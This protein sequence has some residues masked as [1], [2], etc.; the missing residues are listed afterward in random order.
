MKKTNRKNQLL[1]V[2]I[3]LFLMSF[4]VSVSADPDWSKKA[5]IHIDNTG[6]GALSYYHVHLNITYDSDMKTDFSDIRVKN[7]V[8][9][10]FVPY[11]VEDK[12]NSS[13]CNLWFNATSI[14]ASSWSNTTYYLYY[15]DAA[16]SSA[17]NG[18]TTFLFFDDFEDGTTI[19]E[20]QLAQSTSFSED[21]TYIQGVASDGTYLYHAHTGTWGGKAGKLDKDSK[22]G[23]NIATHEGLY[24]AD[25]PLT[26][27][28]S[29]LAYHDGYLYLVGFG[30]PNGGTGVTGQSVAKYDPSDLS[31]VE[32]YDISPFD[33]SNAEGIAFYNNHWWLTSHE[34]SVIVKYNTSWGHVKTY[35]IDGHGDTEGEY[36]NG[37]GYQ[38]ITFWEE[39]DG[40]IFAGLSVHQTCDHG[41]ALYI[42]QYNTSGDSFS[43]QSFHTSG[44]IV[45][46][47]GW[48]C[49]SPLDPSDTWWAVRHSS[50]V[51]QSLSLSDLVNPS[52]L[53][54]F[55]SNYASTDY[56]HSGSYC[57]K[58][59]VSG[60]PTGRSQSMDSLTLSNYSYTWW[61][62]LTATS[63]RCLTTFLYNSSDSA[64]VYLKFENGNI[65][66]YAS[67]TYTDTGEDFTVGWH[68]IEVVQH[69]TTFDLKINDGS[70]HTGLENYFP[71][72]SISDVDKFGIKST[73]DTGQ[74]YI[75]SDDYFVRK[76]ASPEPT[77]LLGSE[78]SI[79]NGECTTPTISS[80][81]NSAPG[82]TNVTITWLTNQSAD[83]IVKYSKNSDL[84]NEEWSSWQNDTT[85]I[86][87]DIT[88]LDSGTQYFYQ[89]WSYNGTNSSCYDTDPSEQPYETFTTQSE[90]EGAYNITLLEGWNIIGWTN[91]TTSNA[92]YIANSIGS[93]CVHVTERNKTTGNYE[94]FD[95]DFPAFYN[96]DVERG[97]GYY[98]EVSDETLW[99]RSS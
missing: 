19:G 93:N 65:I 20:T 95:P 84:S 54:E 18:N 90:G 29:A 11:W 76:Y 51:A 14:P 42:F 67:P 60:G 25:G 75:Y 48:C 63:G 1:S 83:N 53:W 81:T 79:G 49:D 59:P 99:N 27:A 70:W 55:D 64:G 44:D 33:G 98:V 61:V 35:D 10:S 46:D 7:E 50:K 39:S 89:A 22:D 30:S 6:G 94:N 24:G 88:S 86:S 92:E 9:E 56:A 37:N 91:L 3:V 87:I 4:V 41:P 13:W 15:G 74:T 31:F 66:Y 16:A 28:V 69:S 82:T 47:Q 58:I 73:A 40:R 23:T 17:S 57:M 32:E 5:A 12:L 2:F 80:L 71:E 34:N 77:S 72:T 96:F 8:T 68:R 36:T 21:G 85:S 45:P 26:G 97:W 52:D 38:D 62:Y 43:L 78:Q